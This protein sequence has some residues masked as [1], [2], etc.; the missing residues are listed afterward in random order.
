MRGPSGEFDTFQVTGHWIASRA[1][2][3]KALVLQTAQGRTIAFE[4]P[5]AILR[6]LVADLATLE[7]QTAPPNKPNA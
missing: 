6:T 2:G 1:D 5:S 7:S 3:R 4:L